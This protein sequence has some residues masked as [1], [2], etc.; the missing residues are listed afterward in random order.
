[1]MFVFVSVTNPNMVVRADTNVI[2]LSQNAFRE[3]YYYG[4]V[5][6]VFG[7]VQNVGTQSVRYNVTATF[8][9]V[10]NEVVV[11]SYLSDSQW[12]D[13]N[14]G[15]GD[16][17]AFSYLTVLDP[18]EKSPFELALPNGW[19]DINSIDHYTL[20]VQSYPIEQFY[21]G[22]IIVSHSLND[23][24]GDLQIDGILKNVGNSGMDEVKV[25]ATFYNK[26]GEIIAAGSVGTG[27]LTNEN[28]EPGFSVND[29]YPFNLKLSS[30]IYATVY[31]F[32]DH[33]EL[34]AEGYSYAD[35]ATYGIGYP[36]IPQPTQNPEP[37]TIPIWLIAIIAVTTIS[38]ASALIVSGRKSKT[39]LQ[40][41]S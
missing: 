36:S 33:Y 1:M 11:I 39:K 38:V 26:G 14:I 21:H 24:T 27:F 13:S 15:Y 41:L 23:A 17:R 3:N 31:S 34:T 4:G 20:D 12:Y 16:S 37:Q 22:L 18:G 10:N 5:Y 30:G 35:D 9:N 32:I 40:G 25:I 19:V 7:E 28:N 29:T 2:I 8:Y 6:H